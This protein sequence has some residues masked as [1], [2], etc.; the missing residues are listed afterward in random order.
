[1]VQAA[2]V[3]LLVLAML[4]VMVAP[5]VVLVTVTLF[6]VVLGFLYRETLVVFQLWVALAVVVLVPSE[7]THQVTLVALVVLVL[8]IPS[9]EL[10]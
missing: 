10:L 7:E 3:A 5:V 9:P 8:L 1:L 4:A 2:A 6:R